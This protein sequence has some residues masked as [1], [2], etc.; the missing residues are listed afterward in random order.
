M[1]NQRFTN[2]EYYICTSFKSSV[3]PCKNVDYSSNSSHD[4]L[5]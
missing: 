3:T 5:F 4:A 1:K 2:F